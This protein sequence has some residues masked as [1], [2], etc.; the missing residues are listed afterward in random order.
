[1]LAEYDNWFKVAGE[2]EPHRW[3]VLPDIIGFLQLVECKLLGLS[4]ALGES[5]F[6]SPGGPKLSSVLRAS[7]ML[8]GIA[9]SDRSENQANLRLSLT[10]IVTLMKDARR[11]NQASMNDLKFIENVIRR[12][13]V[14]LVPRLLLLQAYRE[15]I[16]GNSERSWVVLRRSLKAA[17]ATGSVTDRSWASLNCNSWYGMTVDD[18]LK[19]PKGQMRFAG[20]LSP[21]DEP[22]GVTQGGLRKQNSLPDI[23]SNIVLSALAEEGED[24]SNDT[25]IQPRSRSPSKPPPRADEKVKGR[26][27]SEERKKQTDTEQSVPRSTKTVHPASPADLKKKTGPNKRETSPRASSANASQ[28][29]N[30]RRRQSLTDAFADKSYAVVVDGHVQSSNDATRHWDE[31]AMTDFPLASSFHGFNIETFRSLK[32]ALPLPKHYTL[33]T[34]KRNSV[35]VAAMTRGQRRRSMLLTTR[36]FRNEN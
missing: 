3:E 22:T 20:E 36:G 33:I 30:R 9:I 18:A 14:A 2:N 1:M 25:I 10:A 15:A 11:L 34:E 7:L 19:I 16:N 21:K 35:L 24:D 28:L 8:G 23:S 31:H 13:F 26:A 27:T 17:E 5:R 4:R 29:L 6:Y 32:F 12:R